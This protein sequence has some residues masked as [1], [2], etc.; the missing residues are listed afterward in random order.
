[1]S[2]PPLTYYFL[3]IDE[4]AMGQVISRLQL[5]WKGRP[6]N[7]IHEATG[8][9]KFLLYIVCAY[10]FVRANMLFIIANLDPG[11]K[12]DGSYP[13][14][15]NEDETPNSYYFC[16]ALD[17][18]FWYSYFAFSVYLLKNIRYVSRM[19]TSVTATFARVL[20][21]SCYFDDYYYVPPFI[22]NMLGLTCGRSMPF[23]S[24][25]I[26]QKGAKTYAAPLS[27]PA[28]LLHKF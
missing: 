26:A 15:S 13:D 5:T 4:V 14:Y 18:L 6:T 9:F 27:A 7:S 28:L 24:R 25:N 11:T 10:W 20:I 19:K 16:C 21:I 1:M 23:L 22:L 12:F 8:S 2:A 3:P 17:D